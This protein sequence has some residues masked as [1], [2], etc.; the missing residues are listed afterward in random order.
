MYGI[1][2]VYPSYHERFAELVKRIR[3]MKAQRKKRMLGK[4]EH[5]VS[6]DVRDVYVKNGVWDYDV[7]VFQ[8]MFAESGREN[9]AEAGKDAGVCGVC[10]M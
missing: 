9:V 2:I 3:A 5:A 7:I 4:E 6:G 8:E 1:P 10:V